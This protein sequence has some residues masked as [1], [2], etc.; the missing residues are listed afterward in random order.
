M[1]GRPHMLTPELQAVIVAELEQGAPISMACDA[2]M[3]SE[4]TY[5]RWRQEGQ[6]LGSGPLHE[7]WEATTRARS[8]GRQALFGTVRKAAVDDPKCAM[9]LLE[10]G[11]REHFARRTE[12]TGPEGT[13]IPVQTTHVLDGADPKTLQE[14]LVELRRARG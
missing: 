11:H 4:G 6:A 1:S 2:A 12:V 10:R 3:I 8:K 9:W 7:F 13:P 5:H 14:L